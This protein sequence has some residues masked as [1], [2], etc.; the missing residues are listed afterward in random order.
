[1]RKRFLPAL[2]GSIALATGIAIFLSF[3]VG[4][5][6]SGQDAWLKV[7]GGCADAVPFQADANTIALWHF[8]EPS[9][10]TAFDSVGNLTIT[11]TGTPTVTTGLFGS[12]R[13][14]NGT[15]QYGDIST[16]MSAGFLSQLKGSFTVEW[17]SKRTKQS[18]AAYHNVFSC[19]GNILS[20]AEAENVLIAIAPRDN[21]TTNLFWEGTAGVDRVNSTNDT[22]TI[23]FGQ[24]YHYSAISR[25][26]SGGNCSAILYD[27]GQP[28][29]TWGAVEEPKTGTNATCGIGHLPSYAGDY[30]AGDID[31]LRISSTARSA[32]EILT[33][34]QNMRGAF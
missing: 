32:G 30:F 21:A 12:A 23:G 7:A 24:S 8:N 3:P 6:F 29:Y 10:A 1:M 22:N 2:Y 16:P 33:T 19:G 4:A 28:F 13:T 5:G 25:S 9:G 20:D 27:N 18:G 34:W 14:F 31:E 17:I 26:C 15:N 11:W